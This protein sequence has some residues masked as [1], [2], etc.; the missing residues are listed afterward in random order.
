MS[1]PA[2]DL[3]TSAA[4][5]RLRRPADP[6]PVPVPVPRPR[7][8]VVPTPRAPA[9]RVPFVVLVIVLL[10]GGLVGLLVLNTT[11]NQDAFALSTLRAQAKVLADQEQSLTASVA[12]A[13]NPATLAS[14]AEALGMVP[15]VNPVFIRVPSGQVLGV[16]E[17]GRAPSP[18]ASVRPS[19]QPAP[20]VS[21]RPS[22][23][24]TTQPT[25]RAT[26][27][28]SAASP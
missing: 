6:V 4:P 2:A 10:A 16:P 8:R 23:R 5:S 14:R 17:P 9:H 25:P 13:Q 3:R 19:T 15:G 24:P 27:P 12:A 22:T 26:L 18:K 28:P 20:V 21:T 11:M 7:L 1:H